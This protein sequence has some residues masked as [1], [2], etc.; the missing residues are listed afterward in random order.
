MQRLTMAISA[1]LAS[2]LVAP[3][4]WANC[5]NELDRIAQRVAASDMD[6]KNRQVLSDWLE[7]QKAGHAS[8]SPSQCMALA[9][10]IERQ[11]RE[12][13]YF[14]AAA[15]DAGTL[16][17]TSPGLA[18]S[19]T[20]D[21]S[22]AAAGT[23]QDASAAKVAVQQPPAQV[24]VQQQPADVDVAMQPAQVTVR[25]PDP[26]VRVVQP[27]PQVTVNQPDP[28]VTVEQQDPVVSVQQSEP[29]V[30]VSQGQ[31]QVQVEQGEPQV[32]VQSEPA[33]VAV[34]RGEPSVVN[35]QADGGT[36]E[37]GNSMD[38]R[39]S[40]LADAGPGAPAGEATVEEWSNASATAEGEVAASALVG[41][42][43]KDGS[44][45]PVGQIT[46][47]LKQPDD[48][49]VFVRIAV[50]PSS[51]AQDDPLLVAVEELERRDGALQLRNAQA[52]TES[53]TV[54]VETLEPAGDVT[55]QLAGEW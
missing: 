44:G 25:V 15:T 29:E 13:G 20:G 12:K 33:E 45:A 46:E 5:D 3:G 19:G 39:A 50:D 4:A 7:Q 23:T 24:S 52:A 14:A 42:S 16:G 48:E 8:D 35:R 53:A 30:Q 31:P 27:P 51:G 38:P 11:M 6:P 55:V 43:V 36:V 9:G 41:L 17:G 1:V 47:V 34:E 49:A 10:E 22:T 18:S 26:Q 40:A 21:P 28:K 2:A 32:L 54:P 37:V